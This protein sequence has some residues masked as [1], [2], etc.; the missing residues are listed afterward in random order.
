MSD[1]KH[2]FEKKKT[3]VTILNTTYFLS[4]E[5]KRRVNSIIHGRMKSTPT[6]GEGQ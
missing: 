4:I 6:E 5:R 2:A 1:N 3:E